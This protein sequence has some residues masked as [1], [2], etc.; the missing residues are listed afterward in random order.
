MVRWLIGRKYASNQ[1]NMPEVSGISSSFYYDS[2]FTCMNSCFQYLSWLII[3]RSLKSTNDYFS[4]TTNKDL[5]RPIEDYLDPRWLDLAAHPE[6]VG[7]LDE[8][9]Q[10]AYGDALT[11]ALERQLADYYKKKELMN[12]QKK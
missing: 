11:D 4:I 5:F 6:K 8:W 12:S 1:E 7:D 2:D 3:D 9:T 10:K